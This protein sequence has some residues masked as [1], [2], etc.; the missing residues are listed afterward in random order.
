MKSYFAKIDS[1]IDRDVC[2]YDSLSDFAVA[3]MRMDTIT[4][5]D[6]S[7]LSNI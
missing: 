3:S 4:N 5:V 2:F 7:I 1:T 6:P